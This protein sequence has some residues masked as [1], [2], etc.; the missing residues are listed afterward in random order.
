MAT[1]L[2]KIDPWEKRAKM[3]IAMR[4]GEK[5]IGYFGKLTYCGEELVFEDDF[6]DYSSP[7]DL[8]VH[9]EVLQPQ[10][11]TQPEQSASS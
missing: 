3:N 1:R 2:R 4:R 6:T 11:H 10:H 5:S 8:P 7:S 9:H